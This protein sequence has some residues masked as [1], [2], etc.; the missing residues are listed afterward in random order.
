MLYFQKR[1]MRIKQPTSGISSKKITLR[2]STIETPRFTVKAFEESADG[3]AFMFLRWFK[4]AHIC[5]P[6]Q[7]TGPHK[8]N[9]QANQS[10][11]LLLRDIV[12]TYHHTFTVLKS[13]SYKIY[14][15]FLLFLYE[16][17]FPYQYT[18]CPYVLF[19]NIWKT[20]AWKQWRA[21]G[22]GRTGRRPRASKEWNH[23]NLNAVTTWFFLL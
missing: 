16:I 23:K 4:L 7:V 2:T 15:K 10:S 11:W 18:E 8:G 22:G 21:E 19:R 14:H 12:F 13:Y 9:K 17:K 3:S 20:F 5:R 1:A 6:F